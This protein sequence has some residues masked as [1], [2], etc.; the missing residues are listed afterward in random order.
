MDEG[1]Y[2]RDVTLSVHIRVYKCAQ[3][4]RGQ[5]AACKT[6]PQHTYMCRTSQ[7][8][9][10]QASTTAYTHANTTR[11]HA[12]ICIHHP[13]LQPHTQAKILMGIV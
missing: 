5:R 9:A 11:V 13:V 2:A 7:I 12:D 3:R 10:T 1:I 6:F 4:H 8:K